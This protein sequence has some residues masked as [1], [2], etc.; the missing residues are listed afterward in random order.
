VVG[1][2]PRK[3][4]LVLYLMCE[5]S[6]K[7]FDFEKLGKHKKGKGCLYLNRLSEINFKELEKIIKTS[8]SLTLKQNQ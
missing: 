8:I 2:S 5:L 1:F 6:H 7:A 3:Q 4:A